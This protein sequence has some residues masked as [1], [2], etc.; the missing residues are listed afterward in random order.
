M[1]INFASSKQWLFFL[2]FQLLNG[3]RDKCMFKLVLCVFD[4]QEQFIL[5]L[6][7]LALGDVHPVSHDLV[8]VFYREGVVMILV[9][10]LNVDVHTSIDQPI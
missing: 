10:Y 3:L 4:S 8:V 1:V 2:F 6:T 5:A 9:V 7:V